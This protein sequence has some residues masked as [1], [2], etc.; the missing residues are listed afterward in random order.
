MK[1]IFI[2]GGTSGIGLALAIE[3]LNEGH[4]VGV[5]GRSI[6]KI[7]QAYQNVPL[8]KYY[9]V[10][11]RDLQK[12]KESMHNFSANEGIDVVVA[13]AGVGIAQKSSNPNMEFA[14]ELMDINV[15]GVLNTVEAAL[16]IMLPLNKGHI[17]ATASVSG[18]MGLPGAGAY[19][20][21]KAAVIK[22][23]EGYYLD[24]INR[25]I[26]FSVFAPGYIQTPLT[27]KNKHP[28]PFLVPA[29]KAA[30]MIKSFID[31]KGVYYIFPWQMKIICLALEKMPRR[32]YRF[33]FSVLATYRT[34]LKF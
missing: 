30:K 10:D 28:M 3:Y 14:R 4:M 17:V 12:L 23:F 6:D 19:S 5:C 7:P 27:D 34:K 21:S 31:S 25:G 9:Q 29:P 11:V 1:R 33:L 13:N 24:F 2:T 15:N 20:A 32:L 22:L 8:L 18:L 16:E 26:L